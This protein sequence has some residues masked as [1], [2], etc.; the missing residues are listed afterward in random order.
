MFSSVTSLMSAQQVLAAAGYA[1]SSVCILIFN[2]IV[3]SSYR[4]NY[5]VLMTLFHMLVSVFVR[6]RR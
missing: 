1:T 3:L 2:K 5:P 6:C 4:F